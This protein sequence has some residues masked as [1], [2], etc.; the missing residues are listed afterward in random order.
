VLGRLQ[1]NSE[2]KVACCLSGQPRNYKT[3]IPNLLNFF[4]GVDVDY[5]AHTWIDSDKY[6]VV[7]YSANQKDMSEWSI[8]SECEA[9]IIETLKPK[10]HIFESQ[11]DFSPI[12]NYSENYQTNMKPENFLSMT[13]S[14]KKS[15]SL[16]E[17]SEYDLVVI[18]RF[19]ISYQSKAKNF[20]N[21]CSDDIL[22]ALHVDGKEWNSTHINDPFLLA[23]PSVIRHAVE[24][25][26]HF[27]KYYLEGTPFCPHRLLMRHMKEFKNIGFDSVCHGNW[28]YI[29]K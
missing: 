21:N 19:D 20:I 11:I 27:D 12:R 6:G 7:R 10:K 22:Y 14:R 26:D 1:G 25:Y 24:L 16:I 29:R 17:E 4:E 18:G 3:G 2:V 15:F 9:K 13:Y 5:Y 8:D 28:G 23:T